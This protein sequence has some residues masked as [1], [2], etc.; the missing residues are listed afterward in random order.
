MS[1]KILFIC[2]GNFYRSRFAEACF[3]HHAAERKSGWR[4]VSRGLATHLVDGCGPISLHTVEALETLKIDLGC[5][6]GKPAQLSE[7]DLSAA[8]RIIA[9]KEAEHRPMLEGLFPDW[10]DRVEYWH[11]HDLDMALPAQALSEIQTL[12]R[13]LVDEI[14]AVPAQ[15]A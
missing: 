3:N 4:A 7:E 15:E 2:T 11:V 12:V 1:S 8:T 5:T 10:A 13:A 9:L 14:D 6:S